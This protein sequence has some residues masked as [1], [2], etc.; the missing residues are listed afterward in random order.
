VVKETTVIGSFWSKWNY[1]ITFVFDQNEPITVDSLTTVNLTD[2]GKSGPYM[3]RWV[4]FHALSAFIYN[5][6]HVYYR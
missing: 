5:V 2:V 3:Y 1:P 6:S 4:S